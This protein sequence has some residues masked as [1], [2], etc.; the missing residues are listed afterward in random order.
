VY[1]SRAMATALFD[2]VGDRFQPT[3][4]S[5]G[6]WSP[7]A[8]HGGP[9]AALMARAIERA[10]GGET[11]HV[12]RITVELLRPVPLEPLAIALRM[13]R[14]GKK[15]QLVE[16]TLRTEAQ[17]VARALALRI[18]RTELRFPG[19]LPM[20]CESVELPERGAPLVMSRHFH[21]GFHN[22]AVEHRFVRGAFME[23]GASTDWIR[24]IVP[25]IEGEET[26]PLC[27]VAAVADFG[28]G[29]SGVLPPDRFTYIN[30]DL[31]V[32][33]HRYPRDEWVCLDAR[34]RVEP[35]GVGMAESRLFDRDGPIGRAVQ[36]LILD[37]R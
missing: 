27:R 17:E 24:L 7:N 6:P 20:D 10:D 12:A 15:V 25:L 16:A 26:S 34:T 3:E 37:E 22:R 29:I 9:P 8:L 31:T 13:V 5:R 32:T 11:M 21:D 19:D 18:R 28:N 30:P 14:S 36:C 2:V 4:L 23:A 1:Y 33:L 35:N